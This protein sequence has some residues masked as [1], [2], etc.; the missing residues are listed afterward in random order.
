[1]IFYILTIIFFLYVVSIAVKMLLE[2]RPPYSFIAWL[3]V[4]VFL[5][6]IGVIFYIF[7]GMDWKKSKKKISAKL[8]EDMIKKYFSSMLKEQIKILDNL[9]GNY[10]RHINL[11]KLAIRSGYSPI[12]VQNEVYVFDDGKELFDAVIQDLKLAEKTIHMEYFIWRSDKL[13]EKIKDILIKKANQGVEIRLIFDGVGSLMSISRKYRKELKKNGIKFLYYHDPFSILWTRFINYRNHRK[14]IVVDGI[15]SY[16]G[17]MNLGQEYI[18]GGKRFES[19]KDVH[20]RIVGDSCNLIQNV[21]VCDWYNAGG[22][23]LEVFNIK[24]KRYNITRKLKY[25]NKNLDKNKFSIIRKDLFPQAATDNFL[26]VQIITS[27]A[28]SKWDSI[29]KVY[30]KMI[31]E[32]KESIYIE[33]PYFIPDEGFLAALENAALSEINVNLMIT[34]KPDKLVAWWVAQTYFETL[35]KA[36]V[37][38]YLYEKGFLH[39]KFCIMD[40][41]I[42]SCGTCN[43]DIRSFYLHYEMNAVIYNDSIAQKFENIFK[44]DALNSHKITSEE[45]KKQP[46]LIRLRNSACR[47]IAPVL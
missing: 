39:S 8:P 23:D 20:M 16:M 17:G 34:G 18:D 41:K 24:E 43:M 14:V 15:V 12:T 10:S 11:V 6:Y 28:D 5:P 27:G 25:I 42:V 29:Q 31:E 7:L 45:Y 33:S 19:W 38:I 35:L 32:A 2:N 22:R 21:F 46:T 37:N 44:K 26:P 47:I 40:G 9:Q 30:L 4:L 3:T 36:G 13:G 1:M